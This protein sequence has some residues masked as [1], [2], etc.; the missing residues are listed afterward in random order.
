M[1]NGPELML[2]VPLLLTVPA[3]VN[4][5]LAIIFIVVPEATVNLLDI[6]I[7]FCTLTDVPL[8]F[9]VTIGIVI[10]PPVV[11]D[12]ATGVTPDVELVPMFNDAVLLPVKVPL[13]APE[14]LTFM[15]PVFAVIDPRVSVPPLTFMVPVLEVIVFGV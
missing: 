4:E 8:V 3:P 14:P 12:V 5:P 15:V 11:K 13:I 7:E 9:V 10:P 1:L 6:L 2:I